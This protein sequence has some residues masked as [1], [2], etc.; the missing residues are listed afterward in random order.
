MAAVRTRRTK[1][2][3][4]DHFYGRKQQSLRSI[5]GS[6]SGFFFNRS[7]EQARIH[8]D[9]LIILIDHVKCAAYELPFEKGNS[10]AKSRLED[11]LE[12]LVE[13]SVLHQSGDRWYWMAQSFPANNIS[14]RSAAQEN[15]VIIDTTAATA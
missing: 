3:S 2:G 10:S 8:P 1:T 6:E 5:Y 15:F 11:M 4:L 12:F 9:N 14:L 13:E 7:P